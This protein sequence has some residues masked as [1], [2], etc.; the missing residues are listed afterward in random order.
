MRGE[1]LRLIC[2]CDTEKKQT[3]W[4]CGTLYQSYPLHYLKLNF[5]IFYLLLF[6]F[7]TGAGR[8]F[9]LCPRIT[10]TFQLT[11]THCYSL[12]T[13][14][15]SC[16]HTHI[17]VCA[18]AS[19]Q[20]CARTHAHTKSNR[21]QK[22]ILRVC[23]SF[24]QTKTT[25]QYCPSASTQVF[26]VKPFVLLETPTPFILLPSPPHFLVSL[27]S[28]SKERSIKWADEQKGKKPA[29]IQL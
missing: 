22:V 4:Q 8:H 17:H 20:A 28:I 10:V 12:H 19:T 11:H 13:A 3:Q 26:S 6:P 2:C 27:W 14:T 24:K 15:Q 9:V 25:L 1:I 23:Y 21:I 18:Q 5:V 7:A 29:G 16:R